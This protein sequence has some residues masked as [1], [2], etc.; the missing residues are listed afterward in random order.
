MN[1]TQKQPHAEQPIAVSAEEACRLLG[2]S[3]THIFALV[4]HKRIPYARVGHRVLFPIAE[5]KTWLAA[6]G[7]TN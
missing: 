4:K 5:I 3:R 1:T 7:T 2:I 6:G